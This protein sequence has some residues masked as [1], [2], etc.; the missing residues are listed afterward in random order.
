M[1]KVGNTIKLADPIGMLDQLLK[2]WR[3]NPPFRNRLYRS[4]KSPL[5]LKDLWNSTKL[6]WSLTGES[7]A[8][9]YFTIAQCGPLKVAVSDLRL[10]E[11]ILSQTP[12][13]VPNCADI[14][15]IETQDDSAFFANERDATGS[16][17]EAMKLLDERADKF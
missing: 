9:R 13:N 8:T 3:L 16:R 14:E 1:L 4:S 11:S 2:H 10:A 5:K 6:V 7:S 17:R 12:E 15:L